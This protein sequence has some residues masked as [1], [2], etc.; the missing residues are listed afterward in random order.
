MRTYPFSWK[1]TFFYISSSGWEFT[2]RFVISAEVLNLP[3][4]G[5]GFFIIAFRWCPWLGQIQ[6]YFA[7]LLEF[8][9][10]CLNRQLL[11]MSGCWPLFHHQIK[12][13]Y[14]IFPFADSRRVEILLSQWYRC[15]PMWIE[16][17]G[18]AHKQFWRHKAAD[19]MP[20]SS[21]RHESLLNVCVCVYL[22][23]ETPIY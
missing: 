10:Q 19:L 21:F 17:F 2:L 18:P 23:M 1:F 22:A 11:N 15:H 13:S 7:N 5:I 9:V 12:V 3:W 8:P 14:L 4:G 6:M 16:A 20:L